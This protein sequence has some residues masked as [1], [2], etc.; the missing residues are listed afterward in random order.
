MELTATDTALAEALMS[1]P[2]VC[3]VAIGGSRATGLA[4]A[5]SDTD[6]YALV[7]GTAQW[8]FIRTFSPFHLLEPGR[9]YPPVLF[10]T[11][12]RDDRV[13]PVYAR[14]MA[15]RMAALGQDVTYFENAEGGH[16]RA[17]TN[18][19]RALMSALVHEFAWRR[20]VPGRPD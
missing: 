9:D 3:A 2:G 12:T 19:Q 13:H 20:L 1:L 8:E 16:G 7:S 14:T 11:S 17:S 18:A 4:D 6:A 15:H 5:A 10:V